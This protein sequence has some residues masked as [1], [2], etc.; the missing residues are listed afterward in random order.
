MIWHSR[1]DTPD[2]H[3]SRE[4]IVGENVRVGKKRGMMSYS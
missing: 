4:D 2:G 3:K 1:L